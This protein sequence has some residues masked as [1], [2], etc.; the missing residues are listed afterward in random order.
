MWKRHP[1]PSPAVGFFGG[2]VTVSQNWSSTSRQVLQVNWTKSNPWTTGPKV[3]C[4]SFI[5]Y[6]RGHTLHANG[7]ESCPETC[8]STQ[9]CDWVQ[10]IRRAKHKVWCSQLQTNW[11]LSGCF[12]R[13]IQLLEGGKCLLIIHDTPQGRL[14]VYLEELSNLDAGIL[15]ANARKILYCDKLGQDINFAYDECKRTLVVCGTDRSKVN[16]IIFSYDPRTH[17][18]MHNLL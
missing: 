3:Y 11:E 16:M 2:C 4:P 15:R 18:H 12:H 17:S 8:N 6:P 7:R 13:H 10:V 14:V 5:S 9:L 1:T